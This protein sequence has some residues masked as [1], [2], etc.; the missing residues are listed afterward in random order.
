M[1]IL[2]NNLLLKV[3]TSYSTLAALFVSA[4]LLSSCGMEYERWDKDGDGIDPAEFAATLAATG[5]FD[6]WDGDND[7]FLNESETYNALFVAM[8]ANENDRLSFEEWAVLREFNQE[9][10][11]QEFG[12]FSSW[13]ADSSGYV[14]RIELINGLEGNRMYSDMDINN[15]MLLTE[16]EFATG[17][18]NAWDRSN[19]ER[20]DR[21]EFNDLGFGLQPA[22]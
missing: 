22:G 14:E 3:K 4:L 7:N 11:D 18:F 9:E 10:I 8:D 16:A 17:L 20:I 19:D 12:E 5:Y 6:A 2:I 1:D 13:D 21:E 15:D